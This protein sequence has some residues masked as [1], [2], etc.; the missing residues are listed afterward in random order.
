MCRRHFTYFSNY[1]PPPHSH[2][3]C[4]RHAQ[5]YRFCFHLPLNPMKAQNFT[6]ATIYPNCD[7]GGL[8]TWS[9]IWWLDRQVIL[10]IDFVVSFLASRGCADPFLLL[11]DSNF[12]GSFI[13][14]FSWCWCKECYPS[15]SPLDKVRVGMCI[16]SMSFPS[17]RWKG[18]PSDRPFPRGSRVQR[19]LAPIRLPPARFLVPLG[20]GEAP[21]PTTRDLD[22]LSSAF[23]SVNGPHS[24]DFLHRMACFR[25]RTVETSPSGL[26]A[27]GS[28]FKPLLPNRCPSLLLFG[29]A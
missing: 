22:S 23:Q 25:P 13:R 2:G 16:Y 21:W 5:K 20:P 19:S 4:C 26:L 15:F 7:A 17:S 27:P 1:S 3:G 9:E 10:C 8:S 12:Q 14:I 24:G 18:G 29:Q 6:R 11:F 28:W